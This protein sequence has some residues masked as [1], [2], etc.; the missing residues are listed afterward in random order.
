MLAD[1]TKT[2]NCFKMGARDTVLK[3]AMAL[4]AG[5]RPGDG[6]EMKVDA[7]MADSVG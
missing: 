2:G 3:W 4:I 1:H 6:N 7:H 5:I